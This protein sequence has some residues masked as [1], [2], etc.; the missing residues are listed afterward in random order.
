[1]KTKHYFGRGVVFLLCA[2]FAVG[3]LLPTVLTITNSFMSESEISRG[4]LDG[5]NRQVE[6]LQSQVDS[7]S[8]TIDFLRAVQLPSAL[9][10]REIA[11]QYA[12]VQQ[13]TLTRGE[14]VAAE[15]GSTHPAIVAII[16]STI[17]LKEAERERIQQWLRVRLAIDDVT[18][19][20]TQ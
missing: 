1:M 9:I 10:T 7:L 8:T 4:I 13:V 17:P 14:S 5:H 2:V 11:A 18:V 3:F 19:I 6:A 20:V 12:G 15:S 16:Q